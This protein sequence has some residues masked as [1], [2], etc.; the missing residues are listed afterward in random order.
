MLVNGNECCGTDRLIEFFSSFCRLKLAVAWSLRVKLCMRKRLKCSES[1]LNM[2]VVSVSELN[3]AETKHMEL[4]EW[5]VHWA[6]KL[7]LRV[8]CSTR[9]SP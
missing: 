9:S 5:F 8:R 4:A 6:P 3:D 1:V 7:A 2:S